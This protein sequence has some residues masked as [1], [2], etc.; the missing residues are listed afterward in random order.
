MNETEEGCRLALYRQCVLRTMMALCGEDFSASSYQHRLQ[1]V[2]RA[3]IDYAPEGTEAS[4][5]A[6]VTE[7]IMV[8]LRYVEA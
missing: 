4:V 3:V 1:T 5:V 2:C 6:E 7:A 8:C